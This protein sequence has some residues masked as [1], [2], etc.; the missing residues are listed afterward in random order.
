MIYV[1]NKYENAATVTGISNRMGVKKA[2]VVP[3]IDS[4]NQS[5]YLIK[6]NNH[7]DKR[8]FTLELSEKG[9]KMLRLEEVFSNSFLEYFCDTLTPEEMQALENIAKKIADKIQVAPIFY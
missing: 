2:A 8:S 1:L 5:G 3:M 7:H 9:S 4:L 6:K